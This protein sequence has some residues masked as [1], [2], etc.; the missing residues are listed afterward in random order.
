MAERKTEP[1]LSAPENSDRVPLA[2]NPQD[3]G[4]SP[5]K[6]KAEIGFIGLGR[7]GC[8]MARNLT[9]AGFNVLRYTRHRE[10]AVELARRGL[11][12][13]TN[14]ADL[15]DCEIVVT[16]VT[17]DAAARE[18][19]FGHDALGLDG[20]AMGLSPGSIHLSMSTISPAMSHELAAQHA[21][22]GQGYVA[23]PV[24]G[25]PEAARARELFVLA[26][27][28]PIDVD[29]CKPLLEA[30]GKQTFVIGAEPGEANLVKLTSNMMVAATLELIS[31]AFTLLRKRSV[32]PA[33]VL[34]ILTG[35]MFGSRVHKLYGEKIANERYV[36]GNFV[37]P[38]AL[39]DVRLA[40]AEAEAAAV[41][42]PTISV[43]RDRLITGIARGYAGMDWTALGL[44]AGEDAGLGAGKL[45]PEPVKE[46]SD[47]HA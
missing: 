44:I 4:P 45:P 39:K 30:M 29:R 16:M 15:F 22:Y 35:T 34:D 21:K 18:V 25:N 24:L 19:V 40:L 23:A 8:A 33:M 26:A 6:V 9:N 42:M 47:D 32:D 46:S 3:D 12:A 10:Q 41:P 36:A 20:L 27:G 5:A 2:L 37:L 1:R 7:M 13:T 43:V 28:A 14:L 31:E 11:P 17:D 38:L